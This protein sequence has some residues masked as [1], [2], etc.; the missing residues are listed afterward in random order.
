VGKSKVKASLSVTLLEK[1]P[2]LFGHSLHPSCFE[3]ATHCLGREGLIADVCEGSGDFYSCPCLL[4]GDEVDSMADINR[5]KL[6]G[7]T[8]S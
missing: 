1:R 2:F 4:G 8:S 6:A 5:F 3:V 7:A